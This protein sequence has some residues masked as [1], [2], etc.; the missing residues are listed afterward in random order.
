M[1]EGRGRDREYLWFEDIVGG[2]CLLKRKYQTIWTV[3]DG[4]YGIDSSY[5]YLNATEIL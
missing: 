3:G 5:I 1:E 2:E 4:T